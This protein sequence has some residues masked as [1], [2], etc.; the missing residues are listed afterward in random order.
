MNDKDEK[1]MVFYEEEM[2]LAK[3]AFEEK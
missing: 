2:I 1:E 3:K